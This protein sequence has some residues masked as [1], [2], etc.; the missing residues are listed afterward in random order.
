VNASQP[1]GHFLT[2]DVMVWKPLGNPH[3]DQ[4]LDA[5]VDL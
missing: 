1:L 5:L 2:D 3:A 4:R